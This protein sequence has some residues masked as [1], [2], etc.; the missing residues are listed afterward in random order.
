MAN[1]HQG[2][3]QHGI[4]IIRAMGEIARTEDIRA[5]VKLQFRQLDTFIH[6]DFKDRKDVKHIDR[7]QSTRMDRE[8]FE[9]L[10]AETRKQNMVTMCTPFDEE[11]VDLIM[12]M[13]IDVIKVGSCSAT[14]YPLLEKIAITG[15]PVVAS[16]GGMHLKDIDR[17]VSFFKDHG[18][19]FALM[20]CV[21]IYPTPNEKL[22]LNQIEFLRQ[23]YPDVPIGFSTHEDPNN[24]TAVAIAYA[25]GA[26]LFERHV[27]VETEKHK[28]N[29]YS[30]NPEQVRAWVKAYKNAVVSCGGEQR[31]PPNL[32]EL[33]S[34][35]T[36]MRGVFVKRAVK[37]GEVIHRKD[38]FFAM[39][40]QEGQ[41]FS[42]NWR[43]GQIAD[44][45]YEANAAL[46]DNIAHLESSEKE[47]VYEIM[48]QVKGMLNNARIF[49][50]KDSSVE[51][52]HHYGLE[53]FREYGAVI[54]TCINRSYCK[55]LVIQLPRQKHPYHQ[56]KRKEETFQLLA[57]DVEVEVDGFRSQLKPGDTLLVGPGQWHK[58]HTLGGAIF[59]EVSTTHFND[60]SI[61]DDEK[62][63]RLPREKRKTMIP[64]WEAAF[65]NNP[66]LGHP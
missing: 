10:V 20:H 44:K 65:H 51:I 55:K 28:L 17:L 62:I 46:S 56:H 60:D 12:E 58:F 26:K 35:R 42:G 43:E 11:S 30:S 34:L 24:T 38:V 25:K 57:G 40:L 37:K 32:S 31:T 21:A 27:G 23:R 22:V 14:D 52:S 63:A 59:E 18:T 53:R 48:L 36:L 50:G 5:A 6:P 3:T 9:A 13:R 7:F 61:Y 45:D 19:K 54:V 33:E 16:T 8:Q 64:N 66:D 49:I 47:L 4:D 41:L 29:N 2:D 39:P 1:N 15:R